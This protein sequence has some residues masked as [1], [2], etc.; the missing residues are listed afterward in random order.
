MTP[1]DNLADR[2]AGVSGPVAQVRGV[3]AQ[4]VIVSTTLDPF[5]SLKALQDYAGFSRR[6]LLDLMARD[7]N[8][9]PHYRLSD[10][11]KIVVRRSEFDAWMIQ[12]RRT[13]SRVDQLV[14]ERRRV[15]AAQRSLRPTPGD[16]V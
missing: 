14:E 8:A 6:T 4:R 11:G 9:L 5:L 2:P 13:R 1:L 7:R 16:G 12:Y 10:T 15:R 3:L